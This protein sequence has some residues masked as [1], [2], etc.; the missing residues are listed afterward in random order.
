MWSDW[1]HKGWAEHGYWTAASLQSLG[2]C[3]NHHKMPTMQ[4]LALEDYQVVPSLCFPFSV[5][6]LSLALPSCIVVKRRGTQL[7]LCF[8]LSDA[9]SHTFG[10]NINILL[11]SFLPP[12][13]GAALTVQCWLSESLECKGPQKTVPFELEQF[14]QC[15]PSKFYD[16]REKKHSSVC[17]TSEGELE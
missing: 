9:A 14:F 12:V 5:S 8:N 13:C 6:T 1:R 3:R 4:W 11:V 16:L 15:R 17:V 2:L 10:V 7:V